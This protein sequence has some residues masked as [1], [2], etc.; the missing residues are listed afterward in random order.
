QDIDGFVF[1]TRNPKPFLESLV[2]VKNLKLPFIIQWTIT[3]YPKELEKSVLP[4]DQAIDLMHHI[5]NL[6]GPDVCVW[7]YDPIIMIENHMDPLWHEKNFKML[8]EKI[9]KASN[10]V[11]MSF[12]HPYRHSQ[13]RLKK[14]NIPVFDIEFEEKIILLQKLFVMAKDYGFAPTLCSQSQFSDPHTPIQPA[15]CIDDLRFSKIMGKNLTFKTKP[16][17]PGCLCAE[18]QDIGFYESCAQECLY[19]YAVKNFKKA[20]ENV[21][22]INNKFLLE[23]DKLK[24]L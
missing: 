19:C 10:E 5:S 14:E 20:K 7:R 21:K 3:N 2:K 12:Y 17:R 8:A 11:V 1:W 9:Q 23:Q 16:N 24:S 15:K 6:Y 13:Q 22:T 18:S 4:M